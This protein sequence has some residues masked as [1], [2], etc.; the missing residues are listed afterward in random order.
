MEAGAI[1]M[2]TLGREAPSSFRAAFP[3]VEAKLRPA[4]PRPGTVPRTRLVALLDAEPRR[5]IVSLIAPPGYGKTTL[6][7]QW[8]AQEDLRVAWLTVDAGDNDPAVLLS[9]LAAA[10]DRVGPVGEDLAGALSGP[11]K[12]VLATAVPRLASAL[13]A[14]G[15]PALLVVDD[16]HRLVERSS[17][18]AL[19]ALLDFL[20]PGF[21]VAIAAR[22]EP[23]LPFSRLRV[24]QD[25]LELTPR[26]LAL[27]EAETAALAAAVGCRL[28]PEEARRL[29]LYTE[30]WP[31]C[32]YLTALARARDDGAGRGS[33]ESPAGDGHLH[34]YLRS[35]VEH[36][37]DASDR[38]FLL[39]TA[40][41]DSV[42]PGIA[43]AV[44]GMPGA[45]ERLRRIARDNLLVTEIGGPGA[46]YRYHNLLRDFLLD[47]LSREE[48]SLVPELH[49][50]AA[51]AY[52]AAGRMDPA[53]EHAIAG[54][55]RDAAVDLVVRSALLLYNAGQAATVDRW[56]GRFT[57]ADFERRPPLAI[58]AAWIHVTAGRAVE[59]DRMADIAERS[60]YDGPSGDG[61]ASFA[62]QR[63]ILR[64]IMC[65]NGPRDMLANASL[66]VSLEGPASPWR[67]HAL[68]MQAAA[69]LLLGDRARASSILDESIRV[70]FATGAPGVLTL[71]IRAALL[72]REGAF[73]D[74]ERLIVDAVARTSAARLEG[75]AQALAVN[76][77]A[78]RI[79]IQRGDLDDARDALVRA[80][81]LRPLVTTAVPWI[82]VGSLLDLARA[83]L[84]LSDTAGAQTAL[85][86]AEQVV[87]VRPALGTLTDDVVAL[88]RQLADAS[89][90]L[91][92]SSALTAAELR[93]LMLLPT[94]LSFQEIAE[95]LQIS[96]NTVK[97]HAVAIYGKLWA[98]SRGEAVERAV[99]LGLL[100]PYPVLR[101]ARASRDGDHPAD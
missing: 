33:F 22:S 40:I 37:L 41:L 92:G 86:E 63:A 78:A 62:S 90:T 89:A 39:R 21:R 88:R 53:V 45:A 77:M 35:E 99:E 52:A 73:S 80:Q 85:R 54:G 36:R 32:V 100:E 70:A 79:A 72:L 43:E 57:L 94:H 27:D 49:R 30:G 24:Q 101:P 6:L 87:R 1:E 14:W 2:T 84:A 58:V 69:Y 13:H 65:R 20:P 95:R 31:A 19:A 64:A 34:A 82:A 23:D 96:R 93:V 11:P 26:Q 48:P 83:Y 44:T 47:E 12:R 25:L 75:S 51:S 60:P 71:T 3:L 55:D 10:L 50:R 9:Y 68:Q 15:R 56:L 5:R 61:S 97:T 29:A 81:L 7:A 67:S 91:A 16:A 28:S 74:A 46:A 18:D 17:L 8:A 66:A 4:V 59:A 38:T 76:A 42:D 98:S